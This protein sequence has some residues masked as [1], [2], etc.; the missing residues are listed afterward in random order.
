MIPGS[1]EQ[2]QQQLECTLL[3]PFVFAYCYYVRA[4]LPLKSIAFAFKWVSLNIVIIKNK[5][6]ITFV[7][8]PPLMMPQSWAESTWNIYNYGQYINQFPP[9]T[10]KVIRQYERIQ[11][12]YVDR[13]CLLCSMKFV[14]TK[15][16]CQNTLT[17]THTHMYIYTYTYIYAYIRI[18]AHIYIYIYKDTLIQTSLNI[19]DSFCQHIFYL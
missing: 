8:D 9:N 6:Y 16:C 10:I 15:K 3:K 13:K 2:L 11:K 17:H 18:Q 4:S 1:N 5:S 19:I 7:I 12:K 14:L